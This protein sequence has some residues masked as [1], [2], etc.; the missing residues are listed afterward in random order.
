M[1][2]VMNQIDVSDSGEISTEVRV[3][4]ESQWFSGHFPGD[5]ILPGIAQLGI[6]YDTLCGARKRHFN[7]AGFS[8]VK[9]KK[10]IRP[11]DCLKITVMPKTDKEG[12][13]TFRIVVD[14]DIACSGSMTLRAREEMPDI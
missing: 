1:W 9:F 12:I 10:I 11:Q 5:P 2:H 4:P 14:R 3:P 6:V 13:F 7:L 8:R